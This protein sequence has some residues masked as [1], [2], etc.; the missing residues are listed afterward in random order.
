MLIG[1]A[2]NNTAYRFLIL[3]DERISFKANTIIE[4]KNAEFFESIFPKKTNIEKQLS[5]TKSTIDAS[6][7]S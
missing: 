1:Y 7:S 2:N 5:Y 4:T 6:E 3:Q